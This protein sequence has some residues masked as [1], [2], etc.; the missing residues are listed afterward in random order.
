MRGVEVQAEIRK[1]EAN[2]DDLLAVPD[3][4]GRCEILNGDLW[5]SP[6]P[7]LR[8][9]HVAL[10]LGAELLPPFQHGR[11]GPGG[12]HFLI[13]P[14]LHLHGDVLVP[15]LVGWRSGRNFGLMKDAHSKTSP[16]WVCE[17]LSSST[18]NLDRTIKLGIYAREKVSHLWLAD[19]AKRRLEVFKR[20]DCVWVPKLMLDGDALAAAE[21]F[22]A[23]PFPLSRIWPDR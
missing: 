17:I 2:Y 12:W 22:D 10:T 19:P 4:E 9:S 8:H 5:V 3:E 11:G 14:E 6:R 21:P 7:R 23:V 18:E 16:D 1:R 15:D 13:E 20:V